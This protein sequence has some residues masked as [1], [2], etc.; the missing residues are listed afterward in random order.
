[1]S[2]ELVLVS[3][4]PEETRK[5]AATIARALRPGDVVALTGELGAGKTCFVQGA[6][7][8]LGV[9]DR[10]TSP[11][12]VLRREYHGDVPV[13]HM[14][15][16]RLE[17]LQEVIDLGYEEVFDATRI[18]FIEWGDAMSPLLPRDHLELEFR[19]PTVPLPAIEGDEDRRIVLR[20]RGEDWLRRLS[21][22]A[23]E[24]EP[25]T[26]PAEEPA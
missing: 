23:A 17:T 18:S 16:Y 14:D 22:L 13:L 1:V 11:S 20:P 6:A 10:V 12:F 19:L 25:W 2:A 3:R 24:L 7:A 21:A 8:A 15:I 5:V 4:T 9:T 26:G